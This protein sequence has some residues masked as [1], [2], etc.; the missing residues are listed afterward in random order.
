MASAQVFAVWPEPGSPVSVATFAREVNALAR[1]SLA[2]PPFPDDA[3]MGAGQ[4]VIVLPGFCAPEFS[5]ARLRQFLKRQGFSVVS[6]N[7]GTNYGP[8]RTAFAYFERGLMDMRERYGRTVSLVGLSL[9]G[10]MAREMAKR[11]P[12]CVARIV[13]LGSPIRIPVPSPLAPLA[14]F[15][16]WSWE[17][18]AR[19]D[20]Q[21]VAEPPPVPVTAVVSPV[22]GVVDWRAC[23]A[24]AAPHVET[25]TIESHHM[26]MGSNPA[27]QRLVA[28]RLAAT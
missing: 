2:P 3:A 4:P 10:T 7:C 5:T 25:V 17:P 18:R 22:D 1:V 9:G 21:S 26:T 6:W 15:A 14:Q 19:A 24:A 23:V 20:L 27:V 8:T 28:S 13:T 11:H 16:A 12:Y